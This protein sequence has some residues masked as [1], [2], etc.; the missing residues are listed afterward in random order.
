MTLMRKVYNV[1]LDRM[2]Q[3]ELI[4]ERKDSIREFSRL[5]ILKVVCRKWRQVSLDAEKQRHLRLT[6][7]NFASL[8]L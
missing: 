2:A 5:Q 7:L 4:A 6:V 8:S 1:L 3:R